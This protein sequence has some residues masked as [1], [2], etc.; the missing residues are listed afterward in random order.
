MVLSS[1]QPV[2]LDCAGEPDAER[3]VKGR[4]F[5]D[6]AGVRLLWAATVFCLGVLKGFALAMLGEDTSSAT[7]LV[8]SGETLLRSQSHAQC[9]LVAVVVSVLVAVAD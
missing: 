8:V 3:I 9:V 2:R 6:E 7:A 1:L 4:G 5:F